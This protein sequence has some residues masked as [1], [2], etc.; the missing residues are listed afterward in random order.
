MVVILAARQ[1]YCNHAWGIWFNEDFQWLC[2]AHL[3]LVPAYSGGRTCP[4]N[5]IST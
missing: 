2:C 3:G 4:N 1:G 5:V